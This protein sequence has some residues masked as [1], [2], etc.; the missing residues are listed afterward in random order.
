MSFDQSIVLKIFI[1]EKSFESNFDQD[2]LPL[3]RVLKGWRYTGETS[4]LK[5]L[6]RLKLKFP[7]K[8]LH[9]MNNDR[10][11]LDTS[12]SWPDVQLSLISVTPGVDGGLVY[13]R[14]SSLLMGNTVDGLL[15]TDDTLPCIL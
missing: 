1:S 7:P 2:P 5:T 13:R 15:M 9:L 4:V 3:Y 8:N 11:G 6:S 10:S 12:T 14:C